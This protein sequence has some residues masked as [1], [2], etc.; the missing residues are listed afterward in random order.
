MSDKSEMN[1]EKVVSH[2]EITSLEDFNTMLGLYNSK[3]FHWALFLG[4][5]STEKLLK[6]YFVKINK[7][8]FPTNS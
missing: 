1:I 5:I 8:T 4:H 6:A 3:T 7:E 2:W